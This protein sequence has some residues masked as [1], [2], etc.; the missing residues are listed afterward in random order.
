MRAKLK[1]LASWALGKEFDLK[2]QPWLVAGASRKRV[3]TREHFDYLMDTYLPKHRGLQWR[4]GDSPPVAP[5]WVQ[6][7]AP[8]R[9]YQRL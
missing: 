9:G 8:A 4:E 2:G 1:N 7:A 6:T 3:T 5:I